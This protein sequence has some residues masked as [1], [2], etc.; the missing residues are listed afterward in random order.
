MLST[1]HIVERFCRWVTA[2][3]R[4]GA[5]RALI[6]NCFKLYFRPPSF[7]VDSCKFL[8]GKKYGRRLSLLHCFR[9]SM[10]GDLAASYALG[11]LDGDVL[12]DMDT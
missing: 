3:A 11:A 5:T 1:R 4:D 8:N 9:Y 2:L 7:D 6:V 12:C 10:T